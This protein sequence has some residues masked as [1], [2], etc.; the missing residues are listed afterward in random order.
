MFRSPICIA[1]SHSL[2]HIL[3]F[4][5]CL[6]FYLLFSLFLCLYVGYVYDCMIFVTLLVERLYNVR[7]L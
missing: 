6:F 5:C 3:F 7:V 1:L 2:S 4:C